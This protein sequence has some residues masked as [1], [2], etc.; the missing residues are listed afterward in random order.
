MVFETSRI[1]GLAERVAIP[2]AVRHPQ[3][4]GVGLCYRGDKK[5]CIGFV[6]TSADDEF[7][8]LD[9][10]TLDESIEWIKEHEKSFVRQSDKAVFGES[11]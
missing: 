2:P 1:K 11:A 10:L 8:W 4:R 7:E 5:W 6:G 9:G 3:Y